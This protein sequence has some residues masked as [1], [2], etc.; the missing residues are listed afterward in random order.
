MTRR[1]ITAPIAARLLGFDARTI[2]K[3]V[4]RGEMDG[5]II[6]GQYYVDRAAL[7]RLL[8]R[9]NMPSIKDRIEALEAIISGE[10]SPQKPS[11]GCVV[12][13]TPPAIEV[14][15]GPHWPGVP[16]CALVVRVDEG[17]FQPC[18]LAILDAE[19]DWTVLETV[20]REDKPMPGTWMWPP[21]A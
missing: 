11:V 10:A 5:E 13:F 17:E 1:L 20:D 2:R 21:R 9:E 8:R 16:L 3:W 12:H 14:E 7:L 15:S 19:G 4:R 6:L 18:T